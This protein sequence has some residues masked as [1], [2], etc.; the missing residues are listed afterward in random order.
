MDPQEKQTRRMIAAAL[1]EQVSCGT[2]R[3][4]RAG[5]HHPGGEQVAQG[6]PGGRPPGVA[7]QWAAGCAGATGRPA[8]PAVAASAAARCEGLRVRHG[9]R[10][11][12]SLILK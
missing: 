1:F 6:A 11:W 4:Q 7:Q 9:N 10:T 8:V 5:S 3:S 2:A 12:G